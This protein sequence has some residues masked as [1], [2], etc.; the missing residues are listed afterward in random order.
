[1]TCQSGWVE[2][3]RNEGRSW[4][5]DYEVTCTGCDGTCCVALVVRR[6]NRQHTQRPAVAEAEQGLSHYVAV[7]DGSTGSKRAA[8]DHVDV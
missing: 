6:H 2:T 3:A 1:M 5:T 8:L 7:G 4:N